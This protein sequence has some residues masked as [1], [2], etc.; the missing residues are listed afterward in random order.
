M[1]IGRAGDYTKYAFRYP[2]ILVTGHSRGDSS[3]EHPLPYSTLHSQ[4]QA[5]RNLNTPS[6]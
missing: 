4:L 6:I 3:R 2:K 5:H 1:F